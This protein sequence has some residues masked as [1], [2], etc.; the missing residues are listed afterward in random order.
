MDEVEARVRADVERHGWHVAKIPGDDRAPSWAF[1]IGL[2]QA[3]DH[4]EVAVFGLELET[5]HRLLNQIGL[6][7]KQ[8]TRFEAG[9][10][11]DGILEGHQC[12]FREVLA[13][14]LPVFFGNVAWFY[15]RDDVPVLQCYW[16]D[17]TGRHPWDEGFDPA[18]SDLQPR[19]SEA[20]PGLALSDSLAQVLREEG[21]LDEP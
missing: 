6:Q 5:A 14:W 13:R 21:A 10:A 16:P 2:Q 15:E 17:P 18:W 20:E 1:T 7:I 9:R 19:L 4:P 11:Y 8:G 12:A 3:F